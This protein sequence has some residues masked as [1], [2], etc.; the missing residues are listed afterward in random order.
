MRAKGLRVRRV[1]RIQRRREMIRVRS[2]GEI[3]VSKNPNERRV[4]PVKD[5]GKNITT[6]DPG[7]L[8]DALILQHQHEVTVNRAKQELGV[9]EE[10]ERDACRRIDILKGG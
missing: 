8:Q 3:R 5:S 4:F 1:L 2:L 6:Y 9:H 10:K 7:I